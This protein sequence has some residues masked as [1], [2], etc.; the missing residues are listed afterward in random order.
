MF[1]DPVSVRFSTLAA[2]AVYVTEDLTSSVPEPE[3]AASVIVSVVEST[4]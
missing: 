2:S 4:I 1:P 3:L